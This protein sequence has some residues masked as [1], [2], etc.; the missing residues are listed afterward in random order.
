MKENWIEECGL[1]HRKKWRTKM[2]RL[3]RLK[4]ATSDRK[5]TS[6]YGAPENN[7]TRKETK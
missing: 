1:Y 3:A 4:V 6:A 5:R 7:E 2:D